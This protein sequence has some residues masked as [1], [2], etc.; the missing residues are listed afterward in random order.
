M[1][2]ENS[3]SIGYDIESWDSGKP[4]LIIAVKQSQRVTIKTELTIAICDRS[5]DQSITITTMKQRNFLADY[6]EPRRRAS[7]LLL[8]RA[9]NTLYRGADT[10]CS[11]VL[12]VN[13]IVTKL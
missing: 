4:Q 11:V 6:R 8:Q 1:I 5:S 13:N 12:M 7:Q 2:F 10:P 9:K 3:K